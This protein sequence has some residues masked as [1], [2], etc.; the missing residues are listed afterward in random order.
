MDGEVGIARGQRPGSQAL[1]D[2][3]EMMAGR[4]DGTRG[5]GPSAWPALA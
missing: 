5:N 3:N 4:L 1:L 2:I